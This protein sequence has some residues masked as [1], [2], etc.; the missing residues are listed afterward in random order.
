MPASVSLLRWARRLLAGWGGD[1]LCWLM[2][3]GVRAGGVGAG[4]C[5]LCFLLV[6]FVFLFDCWVC[7]LCCC[8]PNPVVGVRLVLVWL[9]EVAL[10]ER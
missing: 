4:A 5:S 1:A 8:E 2:W 7:V 6:V 3:C 9:V 10:S